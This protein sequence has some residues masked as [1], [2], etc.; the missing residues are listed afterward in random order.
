MSRLEIVEKL[1]EQILALGLEIEPA[2]LDVGFYSVDVINYLSRFN[3]IIAVPV[4]N[5][6][7][8]TENI[9]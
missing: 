9:L 4:E 6:T 8:L 5:I 3:F 2:V 1:I 7:I